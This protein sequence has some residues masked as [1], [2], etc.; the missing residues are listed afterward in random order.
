MAAPPVLPADFKSAIPAANTSICQKL[1]LALVKLPTLIYKLVAWAMDDEGNPT[2]DFKTWLGVVIGEL[3][4][5]IG[6][7][8]SDGTF[9]DRIVITWNPVNVSDVS[10]EVW[11]GN[12]NDNTS[13]TLIASVTD[14]TYTDT[15]ATPDST[16]WYFIKAKTPLASS[17]F[18]TGDS[19]FIDSSGGG[20]TGA[21][22][23]IILFTNDTWTVPA[24][25]TSIQAE[26]WGAGAGGGGS[27][28]PW[29]AATAPRY[30]GGGGGSGEYMLVT[31]ITVS[32]AEVLS[33][34]GGV[35]GVGGDGG[36]STSNGT[37]GQSTALRRSGT[38]LVVANG[39][40]GGGEG[41]YSSPGVGGA[42]G[43]GGSASTGSVDT[44]TAGNAGT[45]SA[46]AA[47]PAPAAGTG[48]AAVSGGGNQGGNGGVG[49]DGSNGGR[50]RIKIT[51]PSP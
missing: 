41:N 42:G 28:C 4:A 10:Y 49:A 9:D 19:G 8:A 20:G 40:T 17:G 25:V 32:A 48:G 44:Q 31:A 36:S 30:S 43:T 13:A 35:A 14:P 50:G 47:F 22:G 33:C 39:G 34:V 6:V 12:A 15:D 27:G 3:T 23:E 37:A 24:G 2:D 45:N 11:R 18:S 7:Q 38:D 5:P 16:F 1:L 26:V 46:A 29:C 21:S 51:W